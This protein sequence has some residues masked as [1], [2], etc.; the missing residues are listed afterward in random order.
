MTREEYFKKFDE[1]LEKIVDSL[2]ET[3]IIDEMLIDNY[4]NS[5]KVNDLIPIYEGIFTLMPVTRSDVENNEK[6]N[7]NIIFLN[8]M[9]RHNFLDSFQEEINWGIVE[10][11]ENVSFDDPEKANEYLEEM[12]ATSTFE[13]GKLITQDGYEMSTEAISK[14]FGGILKQAGFNGEVLEE[15]MLSEEPEAIQIKRYLSNMDKM[16]NGQLFEKINEE[17]EL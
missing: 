5:M 11:Q 14:L 15:I 7:N 13:N 8:T 2:R 10:L 12:L 16:C 9:L 4:G 6:M 17:P 3:K 1:A